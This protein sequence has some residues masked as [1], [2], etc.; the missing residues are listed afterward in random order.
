MLFRSLERFHV[1]EKRSLYTID[2][3]LEDVED[4]I[5]SIQ[6]RRYDDREQ[7]LADFHHTL[8]AL[9]SVAN[10]VRPTTSRFTAPP[11]GSTSGDEFDDLDFE[12]LEP[13]EVELQATWEQGRVVVWSAGR[14]R[15]PEGFD[16]ISTRLEAAGGPPQGW[17]VHGGVLLPSG[18]RAD[19]L[20]ISMRDALGWLVAVG[21]GQV[22]E[23]VG[24]SVVWLGRVAL[25]A[26]RL[27]VRGSVVPT[28][29]V[30][31][32]G[33]GRT[34]EAHVKWVPA[35]IDS[36]A[37]DALGGAMPATV[38]A[39]GGPDGRA[40]S[41]AV[42]AAVV[43]AIVGES[44]E[45]MELPA[46]PPSANSPVDLNDTVISRMDGASFTANANIVGDLARR[47][48]QWSRSV[49]SQQRRRLVVQ[50]DAPDSGGEIG[51]A[52]V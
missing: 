40:V 21:G 12:E 44:I 10:L 2:R 34:T 50:L 26:V 7:I 20:H 8:E 25:E 28:I 42:V 47:M 48:E 19:A 14:G 9:L 29:K 4:G 17:Q 24:A 11:P 6:R 36:P 13:G 49:V 23:G 52:H 15:D 35:L 31:N 16:A 32:R 1:D 41:H 5:E 38:T 51:R 27:V 37:L 39:L 45:R 22:R 3:L 18:A 30:P 43:E 46:Q 33:E